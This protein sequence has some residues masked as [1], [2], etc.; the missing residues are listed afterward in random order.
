MIENFKATK[1]ETVKLAQKPSK[2]TAETRADRL[3]SQLRANLQRRKAQSRARREGEAD[4]RDE[5]IPAA[6][7]DEKRD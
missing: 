5:G 6:P 7:K 2:S 4:Q 1:P 3:A